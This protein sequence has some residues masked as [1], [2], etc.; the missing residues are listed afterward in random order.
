MNQIDIE[1]TDLNLLKVFEAIYDEGG[2]GR[3]AL[4]LGVTQSAVSAALARLR[5]LYADPLFVRTGRG[6]SPS[7]RA[8]ELRPIIGE[9]LDKCRQSLSLA[10]PGAAG[11]G[12]RSVTLGLSDDFEIALGREAIAAL[13]VAAPGLRLIFRQ[14]HSRVAA[15]MLMAREVDLV[16]ASGGLTAPAL[17]RVTV[18]QGGY[19]C[20]V[21]PASLA[22]G[23]DA[24]S[25]ED[26]TRRPHVLVSSGG[27]IGVVDEVLHGLGLSR[28]VLASTTHFSALA[29]LVRGGDALATLPAHAARGLA[30]VAGLRRLPC[31]IAMPDY[32]IE[33]GWRADALRDEAVAVARR[34]LLGLL[35]GYGWVTAPALPE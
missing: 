30:A 28:R 33:M 8:R 20:L 29:F 11:F 16:I 13:A 18:G 17:Q 31:P 32:A 26:F 22:P 34:C 6:L 5:V 9:A 1:S 19:A 14:T 2:A 3:A 21:D 4:R 23:Q 7:L 15:D 12:G 24:L 35:Q 10:R 27:F 25:V